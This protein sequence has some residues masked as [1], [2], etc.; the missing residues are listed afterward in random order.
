MTN[1]QVMTHVA[2]TSFSALFGLCLG[3]VG[4]GWG[5]RWRRWVAASSWAA[6]QGYIVAVVVLAVVTGFS[7]GQLNSCLGTAAG[8]GGAAW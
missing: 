4:Q 3:A 5:V 8:K 7:H 1:Y 2:V 6:G